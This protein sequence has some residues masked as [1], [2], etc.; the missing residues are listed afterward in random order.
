MNAKQKKFILNKL[1]PFITR[2]HGRGFGMENWRYRA[3][4]GEIS[5]QDG[6]ERKVPVCGT[7]A[8]IGGSTQI[9]C[10][11]RARCNR[12]MGRIL[13]LTPNQAGGLFYRWEADDDPYGGKFKWPE[14]FSAAFER[15][16]TPYGKAMVAVRLLKE[17]VRTNGECLN[18]RD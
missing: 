8:C 12:A 11:T 7:V 17:V 4:V 18:V 15:A 6:V 1:I 16:K 14:K 3:P 13:G 5:Y 10:D 9:L 2:E